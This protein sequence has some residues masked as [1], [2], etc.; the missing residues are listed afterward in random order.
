VSGVTVPAP[1]DSK[2]FSTW[3]YGTTEFFSA[4]SSD[5]NTICSTPAALA[6][7]ITGLT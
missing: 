1:D 4:P 5:K 6:A 7:S 2:Y 3:R